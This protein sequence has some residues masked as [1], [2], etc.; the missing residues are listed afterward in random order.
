MEMQPDLK[1]VSG[2]VL[3]AGDPRLAEEVAPFNLSVRHRPATVVCATNADDIVAALL[4]A[5]G[6]GL[7]VG[8]QATGHGPVIPVDDALMVSTKRMSGV[9]VDAAAASARVEAG[10]RLSDI[11]DAAAP[12]GLA[13]LVG[14]SPAVGAVGFSTGG[15]L[16]VVS[17]TYGFAADHIRSFEIVT[18]D[19]QLRQVDAG[20]EPDLFWAV[21]GGKGN[22]GIVTSM[23]VDLFP[24]TT[25]YGGAIYYPAEAI[26][27]VLHAYR[28]WTATLPDE[29]TTSVAL[30]RLPPLPF[31]PPPLAGKLTM[32]LRVAFVGG[33]AEGEQLVA[34]MRRVAPA[35]IDGVGELPYTRSAE[36]HQDPTD[37]LPAWE[38]GG[39]LR[40][41]PEAAV[42]R[43]LEIAGPGVETPLLMVELRH[44]GGALRR[45]P[46]EPNAVG[47]RDG[48]FSVWSLGLLIPEIADIV[49]R[50]GVGVLEAMAPWSTGG[51]LLN[52]R[53]STV[54]SP[55]EVATVWSPE[56]Y[57]R[58]RAIKTKVDPTNVFRFGHNIP[59]QT[60]AL[61]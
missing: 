18:A 8:V 26:A 17:R 14:S 52:F 54:R 38:Q 49:P 27:D 39:L 3:A 22:F 25:L 45:P 29:M 60:A 35:L 47:G 15:G 59:P 16:S 9:T 37:P 7:A 12:H 44:M 31:V 53:G 33:S 50:A 4:W 20:S 61:S 23:V 21:R 10:A 42:E 1:D 24:I 43:L 6:Q 13:P 5:A 19:G 2:P 55:E 34:P 57:E 28:E 36:I 48:A 32:A 56:T 51:S 41:L 46:R 30:L 11:V 58:L 40:E